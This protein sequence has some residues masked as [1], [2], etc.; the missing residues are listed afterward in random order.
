MIDIE[1]ASR[2]YETGVLF[3][4]HVEI[5]QAVNLSDVR[6]ARV[7]VKCKSESYEVPHPLIPNPLQSSITLLIIVV[8]FTAY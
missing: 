7:Y 8:V 5:T 3:G 1:A 2:R 4:C 6:L